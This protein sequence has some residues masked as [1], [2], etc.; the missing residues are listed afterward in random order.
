M[1]FRVEPRW[2]NGDRVA[3][4]VSFTLRGRAV[5]RLVIRQRVRVR[6]DDARMH[7]GRAATLPRVFNCAAHRIVACDQVAAI[8][9]LDIEMRERSDE[10]RYRAARGAHLHRDGDG[11]SVVLDQID[12]GE[13][14]IR[15]RIERFPEL[16]FAR[17]AVARCDQYYLVTPEAFTDFELLR[18]KR[19]LGRAD[20]LEELCA[21][22][23]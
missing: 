11:I 12:Q 5:H 2:E 15:C 16:A 23:G 9:F 20:R 8:D 17:R 1:A 3:R 19:R 7:E 18:A 14:E 6:P 21:G 22:R 10:L 4:C 13:L